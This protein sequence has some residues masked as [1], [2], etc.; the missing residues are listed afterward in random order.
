MTSKP[1][2]PV[3][4]KCGSTMTAGFMK[5]VCEKGVQAQYTFGMPPGWIQGQPSDAGSF[6]SHLVDYRTTTSR[7]VVT[8]SCD[9]CGY[10]ES[11][12]LP[13]GVSLRSFL[14]QS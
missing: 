10:L 8:Y 6:Y 2:S 3:C 5:D 12:A 14:S 1:E 9:Q 4:L 11:Y 7:E 13:A